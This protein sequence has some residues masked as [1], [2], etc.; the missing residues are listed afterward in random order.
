MIIVWCN[1]TTRLISILLEHDVEYFL[2]LWCCSTRNSKLASLRLYI[3]IMSFVLDVSSRVLTV[4]H[5]II[6]VI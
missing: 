6:L 2:R 5:N 1:I 3:L 4:F